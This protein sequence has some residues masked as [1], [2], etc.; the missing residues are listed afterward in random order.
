MPETPVTVHCPT[1]NRPV[2][3]SQGSLYRPFCSRRCKLIDLGAWLDGSHRIPGE[4]GDDDFP[5][6]PRDSNGESDR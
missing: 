3:W 2:A 5:G 6:N 4:P 1:C